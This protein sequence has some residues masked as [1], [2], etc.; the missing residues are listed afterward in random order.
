MKNYENLNL[1][2]SKNRNSELCRHEE[3]S[4]EENLNTFI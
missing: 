4:F 1:K 2:K 3:R